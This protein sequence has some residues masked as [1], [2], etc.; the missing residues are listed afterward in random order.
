MHQFVR[1]VIVA[2]QRVRV[3]VVVCVVQVVVRQLRVLHLLRLRLGQVRQFVFLLPLHAP[4]LEPDFY[5]SFGEVERMRDLDAP[6]S[7]E[8]AIEVEFFLEFKRLVTCVR[9]AR[10]LRVCAVDAVWKNSNRKQY[11]SSQ[12]VYT[13]E[14]EWRKGRG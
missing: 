1:V 3:H 10:A 9:R 11:A 12:S 13:S 8:V 14:R 2:G 6:P 5:L 4:V 7:S